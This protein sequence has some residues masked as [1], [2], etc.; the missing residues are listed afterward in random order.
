MDVNRARQKK[1]SNR[2]GDALKINNIIIAYRRVVKS[3]FRIDATLRGV[4]DLCHQ[5]M[6]FFLLV[7]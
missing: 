3:H 4:S 7:I 1:Y 6:T 5:N 2:D